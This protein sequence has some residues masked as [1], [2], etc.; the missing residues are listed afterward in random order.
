[1][2]IHILNRPKRRLP[3][4]GDASSAGVGDRVSVAVAGEATRAAGGRARKRSGERRRHIEN[5]VLAE[6]VRE[7]RRT[8]AADAARRRAGA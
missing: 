6:R 5:H 4:Q 8:R 1:M 2:R 3:A 7:L